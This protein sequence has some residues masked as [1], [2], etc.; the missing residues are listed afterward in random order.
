MAA[1]LKP[2]LENYRETFRVRAG[3]SKFAKEVTN[4]PARKDF[5]QALIAQAFPLTE[6]DKAKEN[7]FYLIMLAKCGF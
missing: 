5:E 3:T 7:P 1:Y 6:A 2:C 4:V